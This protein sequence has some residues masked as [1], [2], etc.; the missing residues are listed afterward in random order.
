MMPT[1]DE[2]VSPRMYGKLVTRRI[3]HGKAFVRSLFK[4]T[5]PN[6]RVFAQLLDYA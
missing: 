3:D 5:F 4:K 2:C 1:R 6:E